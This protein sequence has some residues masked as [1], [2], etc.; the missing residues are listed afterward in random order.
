MS[1]KEIAALSEIKA[2]YLTDSTLQL[3]PWSPSPASLLCP[4][5]SPT[6]L[7]DTRCLRMQRVGCALRG[8]CHAYG[9]VFS[10]YV[11]SPK[12]IHAATS[13]ACASPCP[14]PF[15]FEKQAQSKWLDE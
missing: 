9:S 14:P 7:S 5:T 6:V 11:F 8:P 4:P 3:L 2:T 10:H 12:V 13:V 1:R 15:L